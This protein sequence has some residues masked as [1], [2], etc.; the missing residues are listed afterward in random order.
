VNLPYDT[1][2]ERFH[3]HSFGNKRVKTQNNEEPHRKQRGI[4]ATQ[5]GITRKSIM[6]ALP[7]KPLLAREPKVLA[8][9]LPQAAYVLAGVLATAL[10]P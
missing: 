5:C 9:S 3:R 1:I 6:R 10:R 4:A 2:L 7:P 8:S